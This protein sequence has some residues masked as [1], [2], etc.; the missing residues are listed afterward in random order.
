ML[1]EKMLEE[2]SGWQPLTQVVATRTLLPSYATVHKLQ[3]T[4]HSLQV[5]E[6]SCCK[7][8]LTVSQNILGF[9]PHAYRRYIQI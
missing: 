3:E 5:W 1:S 6:S 4:R 2:F 7:L 9:R 8:R